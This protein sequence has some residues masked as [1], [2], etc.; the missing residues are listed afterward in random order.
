MSQVRNLVRITRALAFLLL[1]SGTICAQQYNF[2]NFGVNDGLTNLAIRRIYQDRVGLLWVSTENGIFRY[3]GE[4]F[5]AFGPNQ[6][7]PLN[8]GA[9]FGILSGIHGAWRSVFFI[10]VTLTAL[11]VIAVL[12]R[13][14][15]ERL[16]VFAFSLIAGG[17]IGNV[18]D[19]VRYGEVVDFIQWYVKSYYWPS[20][21]VAD[22]AISIGVGLLAPFDSSEGQSRIYYPGV[23]TREQAKV[24]ELDAG[25]WRTDIDFQLL[26]SSTGH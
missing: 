14:T 10:S 1:M 3:D 21:N 18:I 19:R 15:H 7:I 2:R 26:P 25:E 22:S 23:R 5:D 16:L 8:P 12:I 20:F 17:A 6:G 4:R 11:I 9:A 24:I 13:K